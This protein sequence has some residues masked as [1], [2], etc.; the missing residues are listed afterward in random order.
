MKASLS[1][2]PN[3]EYLICGSEDGDLYLW[4]EI[5]SRVIEISKM[6]VFGKLLTSDN[7]GAC[8][9]FTVFKSNVGVTAT[10]FAPSEVLKRQSDNNIRMGLERETRMIIVV[11]G[12]TGVIKIYQ[13]DSYIADNDSLCESPQGKLH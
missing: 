6:S 3:K 1:S 4:S 13:N 7:S 12:L 8:E 5:H 10:V 2:F 9:H 11:G